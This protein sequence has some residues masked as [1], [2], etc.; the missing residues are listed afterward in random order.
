MRKQNTSRR[1]QY[2]SVADA[3]KLEIVGFEKQLSFD[4]NATGILS[5][6]PIELY[7]S[8]IS[9]INEK[10]LYGSKHE[11]LRIKNREGEII[12]F[13]NK[14]KII[15]DPFSLDLSASTFKTKLYRH[16]EKELKHEEMD[17]LMYEFDNLIEELMH[18]L[19][20]I[21][22]NLEYDAEQDIKKL[23]RAINLRPSPVNQIEL[24]QLWSYLD[25]ISELK[26][27]ETCIFINLLSWIPYKTYCAIHSYVLNKQIPSIFIE[28]TPIENQYG[29]S[30]H[31]DS[32]LMEMFINK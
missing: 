15:M 21:D 1:K 31:I 17:D 7:F 3:M 8:F 14:V 10:S 30:L 26:V 22:M 28:K 16:I 29:Q 20:W 32:N 24:S 2:G 25:Y 23:F 12:A 11:D 18:R 5:I 27:Y 9:K 13:P 19:M 4:E 6:E